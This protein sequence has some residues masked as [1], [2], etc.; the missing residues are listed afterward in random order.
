MKKINV[1]I[2]GSGYSTRVFHAPFLQNDSRF[3]VLKCFERTSERA[4]EWFPNV[5]IVRNFADLLTS[6]IDLVIITTPNQTH[7]EYTKLALNAGKHVLIEKPLVETCKKAQ[8]L[9]R[10]SK[11]KGVQLYVFQNRRWDSAVSTAR[12]LLK[13][14]ILG[15]IVDCEIRFDRYAETKN[16][17]VWKE[18]GELGTG[19]VYDLG[20]H[21]LDQAVDLFGKPA[22]IFADIRYQHKDSVVDDNFDIHLY[23]ENGL[24]VVLGAS[25]YVREAGNHFA[26][27]G[28]KG[29][30]VKKSV[31]N[32]E[33]LLT[34][35]VQPEG[36]WNKEAE[37][38]WGILH[39][40]IEGEVVRKPYP[41]AKVSYQ[42]LY[43]NLYS[44][45]A[46]NVTLRVKAEQAAYVLLLIE[47]AFE[48][49]KLGKII[50]L[51]SQF[52]Q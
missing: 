30:Y 21:L 42:E 9:D 41:N 25:K 39:T 7:Y 48:S 51:E 19:L 47:K 44:A 6:E 27:H 37:S 31:D 8:E 17:K 20:V 26:L 49:A 5:E 1:A 34:Q 52:Y 16:A 11:D 4:K 46:E 14:N 38:E 50:T 15:E 29:S 43:D 24:K 3:N 10:L 13:Q 12:E 22:K 23:Y 18:S 32:Q 45:I 2:A 28:T 40:Q 35:G 36:D 33:A